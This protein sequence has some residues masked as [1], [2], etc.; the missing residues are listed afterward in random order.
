ML[1]CTSPARCDKSLPAVEKDQELCGTD[2]AYLY[3]ISFVFLCSFLVSYYFCALTNSIIHCGYNIFLVTFE[4]LLEKNSL[5]SNP[6]VIKQCE[7]K[8]SNKIVLP[9]LR[10]R[11]WKKINIIMIKAILTK[12]ILLIIIMIL[13]I[14]SKPVRR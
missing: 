6:R 9:K 11:R 7:K 1:A 8:K 5:P 4:C 12:I 2:L 13:I 10:I 3:F 14:L